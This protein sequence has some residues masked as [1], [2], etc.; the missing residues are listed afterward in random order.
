MTKNRPS[1]RLL[2]HLFWTFFTI[3]PIAFGGGY[4]IIPVI[5]KEMRKR[6]WLGTDE[7]T[8]VLA[9]SGAAPGAIGV[10]TAT[11]VGYRLAGFPGSI[12]ALL[13][14]VMPTSLIVLTMAFFFAAFR[15]NHYIDAAL[16]GIRP[17]VVAMILYAAFR[18]WKSSVPDKFTFMLAAST[19]LILF[20]FGINPLWAMAAGIAAGIMHFASRRKKAALS[21]PTQQHDYFF[22]EGI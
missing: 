12:A 7:L 1:V 21:H 17:A 22:G 20:D 3:S 8:D 16:Q 4:A 14:I 15:D 9:L 11:M 5:E 10:N 13:G 19:V 2:L 6:G 18:V